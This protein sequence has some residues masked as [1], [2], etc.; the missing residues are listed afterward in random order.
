M[1]TGLIGRRAMT[2]GLT[3]TILV[4]ASGVRASAAQGSK[5]AVSRGPVELRIATKGDLL[6]YSTQ[7]LT[8]PTGVPVRLLFTNASKYVAFDHNWVLLRPG[9][10]DAVVAAAEKAGAEHD[11]VPAGHPGIIAATVLAHRGQT[12]SVEFKAPAAGRY[13]YICTVPG[14]AASMWGVLTVT[15]P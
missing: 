13:P 6:E 15:V 5:A 10:Y 11:W 2:L 1:R 8:C 9:T 3:T 14:H 4:A 12:V 7:A